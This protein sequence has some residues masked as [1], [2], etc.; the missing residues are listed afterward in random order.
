MGNVA[1]DSDCRSTL[2][3]IQHFK[4]IASHIPVHSQLPFRASADLFGAHAAW[5]PQIPLY[6]LPCPAGFCQWIEPT[7]LLLWDQSDWWTKQ[8]QGD[9]MWETEQCLLHV[10]HFLLL[11]CFFPSFSF[12]ALFSVHSFITASWQY[13]QISFIDHPKG[14][15]VE[16]GHLLAT[17][18]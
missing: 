17:E 13:T 11:L 9:P 1:P 6:L 4:F 12:L 18:D 7:L 5:Y 2:C 8:L 15:E 10:R 14:S 16:K 3:N